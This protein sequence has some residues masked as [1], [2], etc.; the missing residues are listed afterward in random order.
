[1]NYYERI[2]KSINFIEENICEEIS[3]EQC[4][5]ESYMS[6]S[7]YYR[8]F[9]SIIGMNVKEYIRIR[10]LT[11]AADEITEGRQSVI[12]LAVKYGF[13]T[14]DG[15]SRAFKKQFGVVPSK[16]IGS[17]KGALR[18]ERINI[19]SLFFETQNN[20]LIDKYPEIKVIRELP[21]MK[22]ACF[23]YFGRNPEDH[24]FEALKKWFESNELSIRNPGYRVF[25]Y[26]N[27]DPEEGAEEY[28]YE[29]CVTIPDDI[30]ETL[31]D[32]PE[33]EQSGVTYSE[34]HR[35]IL[36]GGKYAV[37]SVKRTKPDI[38]EDIMAAWKRFIAWMDESKYSWGHNQYLEEHIGYNEDGEHI[39]GVD[40]YFSVQTVYPPNEIF[41]EK[42]DAVRVIEFR[43]EDT[44]SRKAS[45]AA[46]TRAVSFLKSAGMKPED[47]EIYQY[48]QGFSRTK[49]RFHVVALRMPEGFA[50]DEKSDLYKI[51]E[52]PA[53][54]NL[55]MKV[56]SWEE[57][58]EAW[59]SLEKRCRK[60]KLRPAGQ[61]LEK[62]EHTGFSPNGHI[63]CLLPIKTP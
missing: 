9:F 28:A 37:L 2:Q 13:D 61:W 59:S 62:C 48:N 51:K 29:Y 32:V 58:P 26:N 15:F 5:R 53:G 57:L 45:E 43:E 39:G 49:T 3:P 23:T 25:G 7:E 40:L 35:K 41:E 11:L 22:T 8:M 44:D 33:T 4:A 14:A 19:M 63:T 31:T 56:S 60:S 54:L 16:Y 30:Y 1:M 18:M 42:R 12:D 52:Y 21:E 55:C 27:P 24:A 50:A 20:E 6:L 38:G 10:R 17:Q 47:T 36:Y 46:W 34:V